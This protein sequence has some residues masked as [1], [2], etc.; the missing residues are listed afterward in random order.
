MKSH[1]IGEAAAIQGQIPDLLLIDQSHQ[2]A[3]GGLNQRSLSGNHDLSLSRAYYQGVIHH[4]VSRQG[5]RNLANRGLEAG[6]F[7]L[8][9]IGS[10]PQLSKDVASLVIRKSGSGEAGVGVGCCDFHTGKHGLGLVKDHSQ[11]TSC[12]S[13]SQGIGSQAVGQ[14]EN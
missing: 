6:Q 8:D 3:A 7:G 1:Q 4:H 14:D 9:R 5:Q 13:L 2:G 10:D 12:G 11:D